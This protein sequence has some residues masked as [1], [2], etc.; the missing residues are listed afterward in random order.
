MKILISGVCGFVGSQL[1]LM[2]RAALERHA[3]HTLHAGVNDDIRIIGI[4]NFSRP[5]S[6]HNVQPLRSA[7]IQVIHGDVRNASDLDACG[8]VQWVID[9]AAIPSVLAGTDQLTTSL[10]LAETNVAGTINLLEFCKRHHAGMILLSSSRVYSIATLASLPLQKKV[11]QFELDAREGLPAGVSQLGISE[12]CSTA[13]PISLYGST[14]LA[15]ETLA[16]EYHYAFDFPVWINRC[17]VLAG[18]SQFGRS[19][20]GIFAYWLHSWRQRQP[21]RFI[22]FGGSG[23]QVRDCLHPKDLAQLIARQI[24]T[25]EG[26]GFPRIVNVSGGLDSAFSLVQLSQWCERRWGP[27][28]VAKDPTPRRY[29]LPWIV[30]DHSLATATWGWKPSLPITSILNEIADFADEHPD[31]LSIT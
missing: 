15:A 2:L 23:C 8:A 11:E 16:L 6:W 12:S 9:A 22:G 13:S 26:N 3:P 29:D 14:K 30:L 31:W 17:G 21:L 4:D 18:A 27:H 7:G 24:Q 5:G 1:A 20:Q 19:D 28:V 25:A 10:Q